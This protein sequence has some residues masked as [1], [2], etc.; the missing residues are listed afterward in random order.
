MAPSITDAAP[1]DVPASTVLPDFRIPSAGSRSYHL[2]C[3]PAL[4]WA[5][6]VDDNRK[7][8][9]FRSSSFPNWLYAQA[10]RARRLHRPSHCSDLYCCCSTLLLADALDVATE[11]LG[12]TARQS[13][14]K[15]HLASVLGS[16]FVDFTRLVGCVSLLLRR[17]MSRF[18]T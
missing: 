16:R 6:L 18:P 11:G 17:R 2:M 1:S 4:R 15:H 3:S 5:R 7:A 10:Q 9:A 14:V 8:I 12:L 13:V